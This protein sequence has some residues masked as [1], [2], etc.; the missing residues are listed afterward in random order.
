MFDRF[1][2]KNRHIVAGIKFTPTTTDYIKSTISLARRSNMS[3]KF[4]HIVEPWNQGPMVYSNTS[5]TQR[6]STLN[7]ESRLKSAKKRLDEAIKPFLKEYD[8]E[9]SVHIGQ[10]A[11][12]LKSEALTSRASLLVCGIKP[13]AHKFVPKGFTTALELITSSSIPVL[14]LPEEKIYD[15][16]GDKKQ[17]KKLTILVCD[18]LSPSSH[19]ALPTAA[20][21]AGALK[22]SELLHLHIHKESKENLIKWAEQVASYTPTL[23]DL[24][25]DFP[26][27]KETIVANTE[28]AITDSMSKRLEV[29]QAILEMQKVDYNRKIAFGDIYEKLQEV[30]K[31]TNPDL[32]VFGQHHLIHKRPFSIGRIPFYSMLNLELPILV[33]STLGHLT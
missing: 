23:R 7:E 3:L 26:I 19:D 28:K 30:I 17:E 21:L 8:I 20:E 6:L 12:T 9:T 27:K 16:A 18:D 14:A 11:E 31:E 13:I 15:F 33:V 4:T 5:P 24:Q 2:G 32:V 25:F 22:K 1:S 10:V 29:S